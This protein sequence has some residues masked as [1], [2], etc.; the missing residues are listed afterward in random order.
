MGEK[1]A[2]R[3]RREVEL[4]KAREYQKR[5]PVADSQLPKEPP[6]EPP[7][8]ARAYLGRFETPELAALAIAKHRGGKA[9]ASATDERDDGAA[10]EETSRNWWDDSSDEEE[11]AATVWVQCDACSKW[12]ELPPGATPEETSQGE[13]TCVS[14]PDPRW[15]SCGVAEDPRAWQGHGGDTPPRSASSASTSSG[16]GG[17]FNPEESGWTLIGPAPKL[18]PGWVRQQR[19]PTHRLAS[20]LTRAL[21]EPCGSAST[22]SRAPSRPPTSTAC[23][24][25]QMGPSSSPSSRAA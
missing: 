1:Q 22:R 19:P 9:S 11:E 15:R 5:Y 8:A 23:S 24:S 14:H 13:W 16:G 17:D 2:E 3:E 25:R 4:Q 20:L 10:A 6:P 12:R 18:G 7:H 21:A